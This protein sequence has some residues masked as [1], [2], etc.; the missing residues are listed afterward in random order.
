MPSRSV[1]LRVRDRLR[2]SGLPHFTRDAV[3]VAQASCGPSQVAGRSEARLCV[4]CTGHRPLILSRRAPMECPPMPEGPAKFGGIV[5]HEI[6]SDR[7]RAGA[8]AFLS[9]L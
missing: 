7:G 9:R 3:F 8:L 1:F 6:S 5:T 4:P 2:K